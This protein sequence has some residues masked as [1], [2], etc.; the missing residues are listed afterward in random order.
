MIKVYVQNVG[1]VSLEDGIL[2]FGKRMP[3]RWNGKRSLL[4]DVRAVRHSG[5]QLEGGHYKS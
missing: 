5:V 1:E 4:G 3:G 2:G